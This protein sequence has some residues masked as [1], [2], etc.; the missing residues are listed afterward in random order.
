MSLV[1]NQLECGYRGQRIVGPASFE[2]EQSDGLALLG[3]NGS[4]KTTLL[5][6]LVGTLRPISGSAKLAGEIAPAT[7]EWSRSVAFVPQ[8]E[9]VSFPFTVREI[10][11]MGR[12]PWSPGFRD[13]EEDIAATNAALQRADCL[14][15]ADRPVTEM[16]GGEKQRTLIAR[17][18]A[19]IG[20]DRSRPRVLI[21][22]EPATHLDFAHQTMLVSLIRELREEGV[23]VIASWHDLHLPAHA[24]NI[25][26]LM[27][28]GQLQRLGS[29]ADTLKPEILSA[30]F[31][32]QFYVE[33]TPVLKF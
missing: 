25:V 16:S 1:V 7:Q 15:L 24:C 28:N 30:T 32:A 20:Q 6:T 9:A 22:D 4:G 5:K 31:G 17:A 11:M 19:Q 29:I 27:L 21:L 14:K 3:P 23:I 8:E 33:S 26:A 12:M 13:T 18:L 10:V 2:L